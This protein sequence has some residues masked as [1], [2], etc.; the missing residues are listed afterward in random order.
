MPIVEVGGRVIYALQPRQFECYQQTPLFAGIKA[1]RHIGY[2]GS[3]G[4]GK[5]YLARGVATAAA[6]LWPGST[7]II[8]RR[9]EGEVIE[10]HVN[11]LREEV[12]NTFRDEA[13]QERTF[14][15]WNGQQM[16]ATWWNG[17]RTYFGY[18]KQ[19]SDVFRYQG[20]EFDWMCFEE[21][22]HYSWNQVNWLRSNRLRA[23]VKGSIPFVLY[24]SN[25]GNQGHFW[26]KR[27]FI[28]KAYHET[29]RAEE[30]AFI[31]A[32]VRDN[33]ALMERDPEYLKRLEGL[34]EPWRSWMLEG[35]WESGMGSALLVKRKVHLTPAFE[36][37]SHW[38]RFGAFDWGYN[39][40]WVFGEYAV[41]EDGDVFKLQ[42]LT[43]R[44]M[45]PHEIGARIAR[46]VDV[47]RLDYITAGLDVFNRQVARG[48]NTP[49]IA[50]QMS[51][52]GIY[53]SR[54]NT[55]RV[56]GLNNLRAHLHFDD[57]TD[58]GLRFMDNPG[59]RACLDVMEAMVLN[60]NDLE[61]VLKVDA[62]DYG[63]GGDDMYDET[64]YAVASR[65]DRSPG[66]FQRPHVSAFSTEALAAD[67]KRLYRREEPPE[68]DNPRRQGL[69]SDFGEI[70]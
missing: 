5:S 54:A 24:P 13:G 55:D 20:P 34:A 46:A 53:L 17:S 32:K 58:P 25:P 41:T 44:R 67:H 48:E 1:K 68:L 70:F 63:E 65:P 12:P 57:R 40:P 26:Y 10:N 50:E 15:N 56:F 21:A 22:T 45:L 14:Y 59:N 33:T 8:F 64:R 66:N 19:E 42:T 38:I 47:G 23:T 11:K 7:G 18:L 69:T 51:E 35:D 62:D 6:H 16:V 43:G 49:T 4:G 37:P 52:Y 60:P 39:H 36:P 28:Q 29:E 2:G 61:D 9:T 31:Q 3:A 30:Y 27:L